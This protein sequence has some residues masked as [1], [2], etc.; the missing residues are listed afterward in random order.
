V[1]SLKKENEKYM[2]TLQ[3]VLLVLSGLTA[4]AIA[5]VITF[6]PT[7]ANLSN[8]E[9]AYYYTWGIDLNLSQGEVITGATLTYHNVYDW[10]TETD[11]R[12]YTTLLDNP[13]SGQEARWDNQGGGDNFAGQGAPVGAW[14]DDIGGSPR[15]FNLVYDFGGLGLLDDLNAYAITSEAG[16]ANFGFGIDPDCHYFNDRAEFV[17]TTSSPSIAVVPVPGAIVL[18]SIGTC[19]VGWLRRRRSL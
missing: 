5:N 7:P 15:S 4:S 3:L 14:T 12:L 9:H 19:L 18:G 11:D 1:S 10:T 8:L 6:N 17:I 2:K 16:K 13:A